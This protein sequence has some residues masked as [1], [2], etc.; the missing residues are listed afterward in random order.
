[1]DGGDNAS[2]NN[3][4]TCGGADGS[5]RGSVVFALRLDPRELDALERRAWAVGN[6]PSVVARNLIRIG[7]SR[8][9]DLTLTS[10]A[11]EAEDLAA[12]LREAASGPALPGA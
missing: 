4:T 3:P 8:P 7:L 12:R 2:S 9:T 6:K 10:L 11:G 1:M 5:G